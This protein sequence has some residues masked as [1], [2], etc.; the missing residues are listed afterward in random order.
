MGFPRN[1]YFLCENKYAL[2]PWKNMTSANYNWD[3]QVC[4]LNF[5]SV[6]DVASASKPRM[7]EAGL[8]EHN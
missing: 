1:V 5:V 6:L 4:P 3:E 2:F 7:C 8:S